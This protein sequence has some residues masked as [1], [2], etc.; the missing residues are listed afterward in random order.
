MTVPAVLRDVAQFGAY[1]AGRGRHAG[2]LV[3][4]LLVAGCPANSV[5]PGWG[6]PD[7]T[8]ANPNARQITPPVPKQK[9]ARKVP[10]A[11]ALAP[12]LPMPQPGPPVTTGDLATAA[13]STQASTQLA[14]IGPDT[15]PQPANAA[16]TTAAVP[17]L[18][19][20]MGGMPTQPATTNADP[21]SLVGLDEV[22]TLKLLGSPVAREEAPPAKIW[23]YAKG[24][25]TL[26]V[27][28]FMDMTSSQDFR[29]LSYDMKS[30]QNVPDADHRCFAQ[31]LAQAEPGRPVRPGFQ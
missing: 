23:R 31:L 26:K 27:F 18:A 3:A 20:A 7:V 10:D 29:A 9:P 22:Q 4:V 5:G 24:D 19:P 12:A 1:A 2:L 30:S 11:A 6:G 16:A 28:F 14:A 15:V 17:V 21:D 25:C 8:S 13:A